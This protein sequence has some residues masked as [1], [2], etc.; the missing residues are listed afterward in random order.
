[1]N[2][3][4]SKAIAASMNTLKSSYVPLFTQFLQQIVKSFLRILYDVYR[5]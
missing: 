5:A 4:G 1:M 2:L 3:E